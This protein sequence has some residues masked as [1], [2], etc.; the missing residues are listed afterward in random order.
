MKSINNIVLF[1]N[2]KHLLAELSRYCYSSGM[3]VLSFDFSIDAILESQKIKPLVVLVRLDWLTA[4]DKRCETILLKQGVIIDQ[5]KICALNK[6]TSDS[7]P[8][9]LFSWVDLVINEPFDIK[10][11]D[12]FLKSTLQFNAGSKRKETVTKGVF[13]MIDNLQIRPVSE[14]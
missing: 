11:F 4:S 9:S 10:K 6:V 12:K 7:V 14:A 3:S 5:I 2:D 1:D 13:S 8:N